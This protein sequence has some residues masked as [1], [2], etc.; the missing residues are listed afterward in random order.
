MDLKWHPKRP[1]IASSSAMGAVYIWT[2]QQTENWSAFAP[3]FQELEE[4]QIYIE[5]EDEFDLV[6]EKE[7]LSSKKGKD[8]VEYESLEEDDEDGENPDD[9]LWFLPPTIPKI[10]LT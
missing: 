2:V 8:E 4:N 9:E 6:D 10:S 1:V 7:S 3:D 5:K